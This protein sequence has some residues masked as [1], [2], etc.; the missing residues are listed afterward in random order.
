M[1]Q[2]KRGQ[3]LYSG[4]QRQL[5]SGGAGKRRDAV[6]Y[7]PIMLSLGSKRHTQY[8]QT[9]L[10]RAAAPCISGFTLCHLS[11]LTPTLIS[12]SRLAGPCVKELS[13]ITS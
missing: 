3:L 11:H 1:M 5:S 13:G 9:L 6:N 2:G 7:V 4:R 10:H 12:L 8:R